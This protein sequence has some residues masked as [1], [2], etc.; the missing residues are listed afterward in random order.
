MSTSASLHKAEVFV[1][2]SYGR[3]VRATERLPAGAV[4]L[5][6]RPLF[7]LT[8]SVVTAEV[9]AEA[10][11]ARLRRTRRLSVQSDIARTN[12]CATRSTLLFYRS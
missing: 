3:A 8:P 5:K 7:A 11:K 10:A 6:E 1:H 2:P 12:A 4:V 9:A